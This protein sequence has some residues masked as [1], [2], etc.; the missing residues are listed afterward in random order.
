MSPTASPCSSS[1]LC[2]QT[3]TP[4]RSLLLTLL[5]P[6]FTEPSMA[7]GDKVHLTSVFKAQLPPLRSSSCQSRCLCYVFI[8]LKCHVPLSLPPGPAL[9]CL[10]SDMPRRSQVANQSAPES[11]FSLIAQVYLAI[12]LIFD[13]NDPS[14][15]FPSSPPRPSFLE[16][17]RGVEAGAHVDG[18]G[19]FLNERVSPPSP[20]SAWPPVLFLAPKGD[21]P[22]PP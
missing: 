2:P 13:P 9:S 6:P 8:P 1:S 15:L 22:S 14:G 17:T 19:D 4:S 11:L 21:W 3:L 18:D 10:L 7:S 12:K 20:L 16:Q 5:S